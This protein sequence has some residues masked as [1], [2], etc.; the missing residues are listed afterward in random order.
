MGRLI[1]LLLGA[2]ALVLY[3]P[4]FLPAELAT[5]VKTAFLELLQQNQGLYDNIMSKGPGVFAGLALLL[6]AV[7]GKD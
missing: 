5:E 4:P 1:A 6:L 7:R 2:A 3:V